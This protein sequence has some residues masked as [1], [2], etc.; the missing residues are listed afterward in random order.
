MYKP[1]WS[2]LDNMFVNFVYD[3]KCHISFRFI[4]SINISYYIL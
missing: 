4:I 1:K 2:P 3:S